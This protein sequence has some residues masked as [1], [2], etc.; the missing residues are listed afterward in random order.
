MSVLLYFSAVYVVST[1]QISMTA[2]ERPCEPVKLN[3]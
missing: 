1:V 3:T 2:P